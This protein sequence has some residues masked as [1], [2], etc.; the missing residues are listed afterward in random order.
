M[1]FSNPNRANHGV[2]CEE[3]KCA[4]WNT[5]WD[6]CNMILEGHIAAFKQTYKESRE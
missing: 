6:K 5:S 4:W 3:E 2:E 1:K